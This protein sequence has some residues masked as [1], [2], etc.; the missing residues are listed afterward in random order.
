MNNTTENARG[1]IPFNPTER[2]ASI[3]TENMLFTAG[4]LDALG[5][6][7]AFQKHTDNVIKTEE[8]VK[9]LSEPTMVSIHM[10]EISNHS[11]NNEDDNVFLFFIEDSL[12]SQHQTRLSRVA[13][14]CKSDVG[15]S[16]I[17]RNRFVS[18]LKARLDCPFGDVGAAALVQDVFFLRDKNNI[19]NSLFYATFISNKNPSSTC[20]QSAVCAY[21]LSDIRHVFTGGLVSRSPSGSW[22]TVTEPF[23]PLYLHT[24]I[25]DEMRAKGVR[26]SRDLPEK[27]LEFV[28]LY[29][30]IEKN[31]T[32]ITGKPLLVRSTAQFSKIVVDKV[33]SLDGQQHSVMFIS[34]NS[35]WVQKAVW[36]DDD[37]GRIIEELQLFQD[38]QPI[39]FLQLSSRSGQ[40]YSTTRTA[41]VQLS[42]RDCSRYTSCID[43]LIARDPYCGWNRRTGLCAAV[44]GASNLSMIQNLIDGD[45]GICPSYYLPKQITDIQLTLD[46]AQFLPCSPDTNFPIIWNFSGSIL[47]PSPRHIL[48]SQGLILT[49]SFTDQGFYT[50]ETVEVVK[51]REH[52]KAMI[53]YN[54]KVS[55]C[56]ETLILAMVTSI[57]ALLCV[58]CLLFYIYV[59][60]KQKTPNRV[61]S[62]SV[63]DDSSEQSGSCDCGSDPDTKKIIITGKEKRRKSII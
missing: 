62:S 40:L 36:S 15:G 7:P 16:T 37:G 4:S 44:A 41:V 35:G 11:E 42:V 45:F 19:K 31:V 27:T 34:N 9:F 8:G 58:L 2:F 29:T 59:Y 30:V 24:C 28:K 21:R 39:R 1:K 6:K 52:R 22:T 18:F 23:P 63:S 33:T 55:V 53:Q 25:N 12:E 46:V 56:G 26:T 43:C 5:K 13:R 61:G 60:W 54:V 49:P 10:A 17:M 3:L 38:P 50:C 14:V 47:E 57:L 20:S 51:G 48:L 32:P